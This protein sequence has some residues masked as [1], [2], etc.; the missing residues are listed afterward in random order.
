MLP[1]KESENMYVLDC[2]IS[3]YIIVCL[4]VCACHSIFAIVCLLNEIQVEFP[5]LTPTLTLALKCCAMRL[6]NFLKD[7]RRITRAFWP[8]ARLPLLLVPLPLLL[9]LPLPVAIVADLF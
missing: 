1:N 3:I 7:E 9:P 2:Y 8:A 4:C 6:R 5:E